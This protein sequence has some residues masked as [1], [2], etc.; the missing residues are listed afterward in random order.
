MRRVLLVTLVLL[1]YGS[2]FCQAKLY[3]EIRDFGGV[4]PIAGG[5]YGADPKISYKVV[6]EIAGHDTSSSEVNSSLEALAR[7]VNLLAMD[8]IRKEK[9]DVVVVFHNVGAF[10]ILNNDAYLKK[11]KESN[12]NLPVLEALQ[13]AGVRLY[14]CGQSMEKRR[15]AATDLSPLVNVAVSYMTLF[16]TLQFK[17]YAALSL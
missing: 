14:V 9:R 6:I 8:G 13:Q 2:A 12:P 17:G 1:V 4:S 3:P 10:G 7:L 5:A 16:T 15:L 11:F